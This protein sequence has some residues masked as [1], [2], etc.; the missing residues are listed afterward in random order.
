MQQVFRAVYIAR[1]CLRGASHTSI[2]S[3]LYLLSPL[4]LLLSIFGETMIS[5][6]VSLLGFASLA[7]AAT[8]DI[9]AERR[10]AN[11]YP[12]SVSR[13]GSAEGFGF[14]HA[15]NNEYTATIYVNG[16]AFQVCF[17]TRGYHGIL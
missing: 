11:S 7:F 9:P 16:V 14:S 1:R 13:S 2:S 6:L 5:R 10:A 8:I 12:V 15:G 4:I 17:L 3:L